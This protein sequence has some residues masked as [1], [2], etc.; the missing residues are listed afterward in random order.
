MCGTDFDTKEY[1]DNWMDP[2]HH[3]DEQKFQFEEKIDN[4][5]H[6]VT[7][8]RENMYI[9]WDYFHLIFNEG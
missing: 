3:K 2:V 7:L 9:P 5:N 6:T 1:G 8:I 4:I